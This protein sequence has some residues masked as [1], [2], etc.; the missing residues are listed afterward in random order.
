MTNAK[1]V[2]IA[3]MFHSVG[4]MAKKGRAW[5]SL[6]DELLRCG[7]GGDD[8]VQHRL[9]LLSEID[10]CRGSSLGFARRDLRGRA[11]RDAS[12]DAFDAQQPSHIHLGG[13]RPRE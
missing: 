12:G 5:D 8:R 3:E 7:D 1:S 11:R 6:S 10:R 2:F 13:L 9:S 4:E